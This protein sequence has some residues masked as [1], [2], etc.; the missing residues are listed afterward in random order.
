MKSQIILDKW[1]DLGNNYLQVEFDLQDRTYVY[2]TVFDR[3][4]RLLIDSD[5]AKEALE[6]SMK[7]GY[8]Y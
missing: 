2:P 3:K 7:D 6:R 8:K 4:G 1:K 5:E